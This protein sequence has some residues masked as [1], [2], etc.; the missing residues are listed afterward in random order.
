M[1]FKSAA[2]RPNLRWTSWWIFDHAPQRT[3]TSTFQLWHV[4]R[5]DSMNVPVN[6]VSVHVDFE[7]S[8]YGTVGLG[9]CEKVH[10][11]YERALVS[12]CI[13]REGANS[14][15]GIE[16][17]LVFVSVLVAECFPRNCFVL[18]LYHCGYRAAPQVAALRAHKKGTP[19]VW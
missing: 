3:A 10:S 13:E 8:D 15:V 14:A 7:V 2:M 11:L 1:R 17:N 16:Q 4:D 12:R 18:S 9:A 6:A 5:L 19:S